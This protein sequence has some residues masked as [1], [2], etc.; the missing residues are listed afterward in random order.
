MLR[1]CNDQ[2]LRQDR[3]LEECG[4]SVEMVAQAVT[5]VYEI[6]DS[7]DARLLEAGGDR[8]SDLVELANLSA[9]IGNLFRA[10]IVRAAGGRFTANTRIPILTYSVELPDA[11]TLRSK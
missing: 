9:I 11:R 7:I 1:C 6:L 10:G 2:Y 8:L 3:A 4:L 5:Y